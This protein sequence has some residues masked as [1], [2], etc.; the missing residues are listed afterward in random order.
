MQ[1]STQRH[2]TEI[3]KE[4]FRECFVNMRS[5]GIPPRATLVCGRHPRPILVNST[6]HQISGSGLRILPLPLEDAPQFAAYPTVKFFEDTFNHRQSE[7]VN[8]SSHYR[9][10]RLGEPFK[11]T[12]SS[13]SEQF[14][15]FAF[16]AF[17]AGRCDLEPRLQIERHA[18]SEELS[19][20]GTVNRTFIPVHLE[21]Q[22]F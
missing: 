19:F 3:I 4:A 18:V 22:P 15:E 14:T 1:L 21:L 10:K 13:L 9:C 17:N 16:Q 12:P 2:E 11:V 5:A 7:V 8:P 20:P 6:F